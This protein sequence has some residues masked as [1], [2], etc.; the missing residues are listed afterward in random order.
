MEDFAQFALITF[1]SVLFIVDPFAALPSYLAVRLPVHEPNGHGY[2]DGWS[3]LIDMDKVS[4]L[5]LE[6]VFTIG[7]KA[8]TSQEVDLPTFCGTK[9][10]EAPPRIR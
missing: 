4:V 8:Q 10:I 3:L 7:L 6:A 1:T 2:Y 5:R 9:T